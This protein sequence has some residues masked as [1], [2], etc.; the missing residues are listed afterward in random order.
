[1]W[2]LLDLLMILVVDPRHFHIRF[3]NRL[4]RNSKE[5]QS[6]ET[7]ENSLIELLIQ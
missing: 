3:F 6:S 4:E 5:E 7:M 2:K 1:M